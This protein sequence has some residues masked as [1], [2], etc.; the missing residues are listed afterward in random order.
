M[1]HSRAR[2]S[3]RGDGVIEM[4]T[5]YTGNWIEM[6]TNNIYAKLDGFTVH[7]CKSLW[8]V[9]IL[10]DLNVY[11]VVIPKMNAPNFIS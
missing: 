9:F 1:L 4:K 11:N 6:N 5:T 10:C 7:V 2:R 8:H 3:R